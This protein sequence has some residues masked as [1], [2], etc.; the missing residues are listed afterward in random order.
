MFYVEGTSKEV[1]HGFYIFLSFF[2][3]SCLN[4]KAADE[5]MLDLQLSDLL[6][7]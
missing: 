7:Q 4:H 2:L 5:I 1:A 6:I 3:S